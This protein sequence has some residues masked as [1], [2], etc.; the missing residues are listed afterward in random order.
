[1]RD[2][3][4]PEGQSPTPRICCPGGKAARSL[5]GRVTY[6]DGCWDEA[7]ADWV[8]QYEDNRDPSTPEAPSL[9]EEL[10]RTV[11]PGRTC[12]RRWMY[13]KWRLG[14]RDEWGDEQDAYDM[15]NAAIAKAK[16][17]NEDGT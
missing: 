9:A 5:P 15:A 13:T 4:L 14:K 2:S 10:E 3:G 8:S 12:W 7:A 1:M 6:C 16:G 11:T 17:D